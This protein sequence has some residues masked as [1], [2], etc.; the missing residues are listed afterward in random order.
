MTR[1]A[2]PTVLLADDSA[3]MVMQLSEAIQMRAPEF[4]VIGA[5]NG[6][7]AIEILD[8]RPI[9]LLVTD[10]HMPIADGFEVLTHVKTHHSNLPFIVLS[11]MPYD[12]IEA[13]LDPFGALPFLSK[14]VRA[15]KLVEKM[16]ALLEEVSA[17]SIVGVT[18]PNLLQ[19]L[20][21]ERKSCSVRVTNA[22]GAW[23]RLHFLSGKLVNAYLAAGAEGSEGEIEGEA[24]A[25]R[26]LSW[27]RADLELERSYHNH[28]AK[29]E[30]SLQELLLDTARE[31]DESAAATGDDTTR[32]GTHGGANGRTNG[33]TNGGA[34]EASNVAPS[35]GSRATR[36]SAPPSASSPDPG[37][38][39]PKSEDPAAALL[40]RRIE[41]LADALDAAARALSEARTELEALR[42]AQR[43][44]AATGD[45][46]GEGETENA[47]R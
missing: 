4:T 6:E 44:T 41:A 27:E 19:L 33:K 18:L 7:R 15:G 35:A 25:R 39:A 28:I 17:G 24:A 12:R 42:V 13:Q 34:A 30:R 26:I 31:V 14:P 20:E 38:D 1:L 46:Q 16:R 45:D 11:G 47:A 23:G 3:S 5:H 29:I 32:G 22:S 10:L 36:P 43:E 2:N 9:D 21:W 40:E 8:T 37:T